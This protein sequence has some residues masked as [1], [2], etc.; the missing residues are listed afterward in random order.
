MRTQEDVEAVRSLICCLSYEDSNT[1]RPVHINSIGSLLSVQ[2]PFAS[3]PLACSLLAELQEVCRLPGGFLFPA[4]LRQIPWHGN[5]LFVGPHST[6]ELKRAIDARIELVGF[7]RMVY[8]APSSRVGIQSFEHWLD[9]PADLVAWGKAIFSQGT[10]ALRPTLDSTGSIEAY[11]PSFTSRWTS[12]SGRTRLQDGIYLCRRQLSE[13]DKRYFIGS[14]SS[15]ALVGETPFDS[16]VVDHAR[17][18]YAIDAMAGFRNGYQC[19]FRPSS[20]ILEFG[21][22]LP[23]AEKRLMTAIAISD[24][25][26]SHRPE[27]ELPRRLFADVEHELAKIGLYRGALL[28]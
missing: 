11:S 19:R 22:R 17:M 27:Y 5:T 24:E 21:Y 4:P 15:N 8:S 23:T 3:S 1:A 7:G 18:R 9:R 12:I 14:I 16:S 2:S 13:H 25:P 20:V 10:A 6:W 28:S 26:D